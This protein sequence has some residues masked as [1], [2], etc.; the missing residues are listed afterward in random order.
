[1]TFSLATNPPG[2]VVQASIDKEDQCKTI[3]DSDNKGRLVCIGEAILAS[4]KH[5][6]YL[7]FLICNTV[8]FIASLS[9]ILFLVS[10]IPINHPFPVWFLSTGMCITLTSLALTYL[11]AANMVTPNTLWNSVDDNAFGIALIVWIVIVSI[12]AVILIVRLFVR[13]VNKCY[14]K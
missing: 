13:I 12:V 9:I 7:K 11:Y 5:S 14:K 6:S 1:M 8:C 2:G 3:I 4:Y 10:G